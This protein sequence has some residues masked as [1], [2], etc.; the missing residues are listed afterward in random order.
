MTLVEE[1]AHTTEVMESCIE[2]V[3]TYEQAYTL[4]LRSLV[5]IRQ[6]NHYIAELKG[7]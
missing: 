1:L 7:I 4:L 3:V 2:R 5:E 6:L